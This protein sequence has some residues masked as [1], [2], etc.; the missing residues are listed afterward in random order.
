MCNYCKT[1]VFAGHKAVQL[2]ERKYGCASY[3]GC[4]RAQLTENVTDVQL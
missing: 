4:K 3:S 1:L 2:K